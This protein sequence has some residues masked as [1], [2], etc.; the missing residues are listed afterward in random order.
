MAFIFGP[1]G[2]SSPSIGGGITSGTTGSVLFVGSGATIAQDNANFF[3]DDTNNRLGIGT[4]SPAYQFD[5]ANNGRVRHQAGVGGG[6]WYNSVS[7]AAK[8]FVGTAT[9]DNQRFMFYAGAAIVQWSADEGSN[10]TFG[11]LQNTGISSGNQDFCRFTSTIVQTSTGGYTMLNML[12]TE[13]ST[14]SG[15]KLFFNCQVGGSSRYK[16]TS[17]GLMYPQK[18]DTAGG[19]TGA[20]TINKPSGSVNFAAG[21]T[22]LTVTNNLVTTSSHVFAVVQTNDTTAEI[23]NVVP[24]SGSF[25]INL[26]AAATAETRVAFLVIGA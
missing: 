5:L 13:S 10:P 18:T 4:N 19:T 3:W 7:S 16:V 1:G 22:A 21:A 11:F 17:Q 15:E 6:F 8:W 23:K 2:G 9:S 24:A 12:V 20:V 25:T 14:G 26:V